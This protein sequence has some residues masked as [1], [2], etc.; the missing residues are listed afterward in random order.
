MY[1]PGSPVQM[2]AGAFLEDLKKRNLRIDRIA[3][4]HG[5]VATYAQFLKDAAMPVPAVGAG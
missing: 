1:T 4:L 3:P 2:F 5:T